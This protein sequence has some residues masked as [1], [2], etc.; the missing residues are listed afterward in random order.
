MPNIQDFLCPLS[1]S[2]KW[3]FI[4]LIIFKTRFLWPSSQHLYES[5]HAKLPTLGLILVGQ[6]NTPCPKNKIHSQRPREQPAPQPNQKKNE[7][8]GTAHLC[9]RR[10]SFCMA[11]I[12]QLCSQSITLTLLMSCLR[13]MAIV[14]SARSL[15]FRSQ[16]LG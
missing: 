8:F 4:I 6:F 13:A 15:S 2:L 11:I 9:F 16:F 12:C 7:T 14:D 5:P 10:H 1:I 3:K